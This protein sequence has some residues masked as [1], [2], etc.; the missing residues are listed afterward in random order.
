MHRVHDVLLSW[1]PLGVFLFALIESAGIPNPG[2]TDVFLLVL[3]IAHADPWLCA[4]LAVCGSLI[5]SAIFFEIMCRGGERVLARY[6]SS[7]RGQ[8]FRIWFLRYGLVTVFIP[9]L[10][11]I[12]FLPFKVF[13]ACA[14]AL[15]HSRIRFLLVLAAGRIP[16]YFA[17]AYLGAELGENS[18]HWVAGHMWQLVAVAVVLSALL[19]ML[20]RFSGRQQSQRP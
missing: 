17:L 4:S 12:P 8:R 7:G 13:A 2:G 9:A 20:I 10:L 6:V 1:G 15:G 16:R 18:M 11:P 14:G 19:Y 3:T 5:G